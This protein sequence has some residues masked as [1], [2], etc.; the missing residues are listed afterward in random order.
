MAV[1]NV[2]TGHKDAVGSFLQRFEDEVGIDPSR[3]HDPDDAHLRGVL[4]SADPG[5]VSRGVGAPV[6]CKGD[7]VG[8][9]FFWHASSSFLFF[10]E[11]KK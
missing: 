5:Q 11:N 7:D 3:A 9:E 6:A 1:A 8:F 2:S 10:I 4:H